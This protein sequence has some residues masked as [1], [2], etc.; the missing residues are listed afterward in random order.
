MGKRQ[1]YIS[2]LRGGHFGTPVMIQKQKSWLLLFIIIILFTIMKIIMGL[3][4]PGLQYA[5]T[6]HNAGAIFV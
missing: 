3:G 6:R 2:Q 4:N 1:K 5:Q